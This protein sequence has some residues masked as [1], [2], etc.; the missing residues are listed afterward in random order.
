MNIETNGGKNRERE[1]KKKW[2]GVGF[3]SSKCRSMYI[4]IIWL[5]VPHLYLSPSNVFKI[6][7]EVGF[8]LIRSI[9]WW[10]NM[11]FG[12]KTPVLLPCNISLRWLWSY[13]TMD[14]VW[15]KRI[16]RCPSA[17]CHWNLQYLL[18]IFKYGS[19]WPYATSMSVGG[20]NLGYICFG[21]IS[22]FHLFLPPFVQTQKCFQALLF[23]CVN[24]IC[25]NSETF[26]KHQH[27]SLVGG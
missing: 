2:F 13:F 18:L 9:T 11:H 17:S 6:N 23:F 20:I 1:R 3:F 14:F 10:E 16:S 22:C 19:I 5:L 15:N 4:K 25:N 27:N 21:H 26:P 24:S 8:I 12:R 7:W